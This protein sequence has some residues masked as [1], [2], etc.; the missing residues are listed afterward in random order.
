MSRRYSVQVPNAIEWRCLT[1]PGLAATRPPATVT[2]ATRNSPRPAARCNCALREAVNLGRPEL[3]GALDGGGYPCRSGG[4]VVGYN[5]MLD[6]PDQRQPWC[7]KRP[8]R[9]GPAALSLEDCP[10]CEDPPLNP[11]AGLGHS[12]ARRRPLRSSRRTAGARANAGSDTRRATPLI[13][14]PTWSTATTTTIASA[15]SAARPYPG[16]PSLNTNPLSGLPN[17][18][19]FSCDAAAGHSNRGNTERPAVRC[20]M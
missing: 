5:P 4:R 18:P 6:S 1:Y 14:A 11:R 16:K 17:V 8:H 19:G 20:Q 15:A 13:C 9:A 10:A 7:A 3:A 2:A 12:A